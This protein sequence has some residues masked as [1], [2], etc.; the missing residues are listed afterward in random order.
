MK[1]V[2]I[3]T[4][5]CL[6]SIGANKVIRLS[7]LSHLHKCIPNNKYSY[8][9]HNSPPHICRHTPINLLWKTSG[10]F[11]PRP[12]PHWKLDTPVCTVFWTRHWRF[13]LF[14]EEE[15]LLLFFFSLS[16]RFLNLTW[17]FVWVLPFPKMKS[18]PPL[19]GTFCIREGLEYR[20]LHDLRSVPKAKVTGRKSGPFP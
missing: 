19:W 17:L 13:I 11:L 5:I 16:G 4:F 18:S 15:C 3:C 2:Y 7:T 8:Q 9:V 10:I 6:G 1:F 12:V 20:P 14:V